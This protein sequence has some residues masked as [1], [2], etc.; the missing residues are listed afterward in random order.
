MSDFTT[1]SQAQAEG[2]DKWKIA[3]AKGVL[4]MVTPTEYKTGVPSP[5]TKKDGT[6]LT[7]VV[8]AQVVE[9][10]GS[11][12]GTV[13]DNVWIF[14]GVLISQLKAAVAKSRVLGRLFIGP[15]TGPGMS[16]PFTLADP[17]PEDVVAAQ[18]YVNAAS[19]A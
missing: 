7:D 4:L 13:H 11:D 19:I 17:T 15:P 3:S 12:A 2:S 14:Q 9:I 5:Y 10:D 8:V 16:G 6:K 1:P 18:A